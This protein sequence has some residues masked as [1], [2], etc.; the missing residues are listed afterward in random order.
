MVKAKTQNSTKKLKQKRRKK[1]DSMRI[2]VQS[3]EYASAKQQR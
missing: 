3:D 2:N 1:T